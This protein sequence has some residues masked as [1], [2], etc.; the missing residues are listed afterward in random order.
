MVF[1]VAGEG[2]DAIRAQEFLF[3]EHASQDTAQP[4]LIYECSDT[5]TCKSPVTRPACMYA[6]TQLGHT[7]H[8]FLQDVHHSRHSFA[9]PLLDYGGGTQGQQAHY[10]THLE[11]FGT[12]V[13]QA[14]HIVVE[15]I[16]LV[17]HPLRPHLV[18]GCCD[19]NE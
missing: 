4:V 6:V 5:A 2:P 19:P 17:P 16:L 1:M 7:L 11:P 10:G 8:P 9:L 15:T 3:V 13:R 14:Q 18:H 12:T